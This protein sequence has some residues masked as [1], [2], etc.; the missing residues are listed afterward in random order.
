MAGLATGS[1]GLDLV[2]AL[3]ALW[4]DGDDA[5]AGLAEERVVTADLQVLAT[6]V[7]A[8]GA[9]CVPHPPGAVPGRLLRLNHG[10]VWRRVR[11]RTG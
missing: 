2:L 5:P 7:T 11:R 9:V 1:G 6:Q 4:N 3:N 10:V 8:D